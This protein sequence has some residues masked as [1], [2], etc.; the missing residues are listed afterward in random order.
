[1]RTVLAGQVRAECPQEVAKPWTQYPGLMGTLVDSQESKALLTFSL[2]TE[3][4]SS[5]STCRSFFATPMQGRSVR[6]PRWQATPKPARDQGSE[7]DGGDE[8]GNQPESLI[9]RQ[10]TL[11]WEPS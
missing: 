3:L 6:T 8:I 5:P 9:H 1:M 4:F 10:Q 7:L 2:C 11:E